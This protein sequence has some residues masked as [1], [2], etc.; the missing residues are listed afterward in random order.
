M[1]DH[2]HHDYMLPYFYG[3]DDLKLRYQRIITR[4]PRSERSST[5]QVNLQKLEEFVSSKKKH[6]LLQFFTGSRP[7]AWV[8]VYDE[9]TWT[10]RL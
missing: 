9:D 7:D 8:N 3:N 5:A 10:T 4:Y 1:C 6:D 2:E